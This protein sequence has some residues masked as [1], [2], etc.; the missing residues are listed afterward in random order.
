MEARDIVLDSGV[1][2]TYP[3]GYL[4]FLLK[5]DR[6]NGAHRSLFIASSAARPCWPGNL[7]RGLRG[8]GNPMKSAVALILVLFVA[9]AGGMKGK[10]AAEG[11]KPVGGPSPKPKP[12][13]SGSI[14]CLGTWHGVWVQGNSTIHVHRT[15]AVA[16][17]QD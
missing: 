11:K 6:I 10:T 5:Y 13:P 12:P 15:G 7:S 2:C 9:T 17:P 4:C 14:C 8:N 3:V 16:Y 1:E